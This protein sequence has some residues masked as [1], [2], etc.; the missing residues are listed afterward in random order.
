MS[1]FPQARWILLP[2]IVFLALYIIPAASATEGAPPLDRELARDNRTPIH[3]LFP[4]IEPLG[5]R[6]LEAGRHA[7]SLRL[8]YGSVFVDKT[9]G[10]WEVLMDMEMMVATLE[11]RTGLPRK[12][13][14]MLQLPLVLYHDG[15]M[16]GFL[17]SYHSALGVG[18]YGR[19]NRPDDEFA[20]RIT[21]DGKPWFTGQGDGWGLGDARLGVKKRVARWDGGVLSG[22]AAI[23]APTGSSSEGRGSGAWDGVFTLLA[24]QRLPHGFSVQAAAGYAIL[25]SPDTAAGFSVDVD[26]VVS[27]ALGLRFDPWDS[28]GLFVRS[29]A[30]SSPFGDTGIENLDR[31]SAEITFGVRLQPGSGTAVEIALS[32]DLTRAGAD[33]VFHLGMGIHF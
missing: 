5:A 16:D 10:A 1:S 17:E 19:E 27:G 26:N 30:S 18:N 29:L 4:M 32:E 24:D 2:G 14:M 25:G 3:R 7:P 31:T 21:K 11:W 23:E 20:Y 15:F 13:E 12:W 28:A 8:S 22:A 6:I 9:G 33:F